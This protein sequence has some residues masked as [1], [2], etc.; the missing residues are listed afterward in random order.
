M[1]MDDEVKLLYI[2]TGAD[3]MCFFSLFGGI[4]SNR[5]KLIS[6]TLI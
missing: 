4:K 3:S 5:P 2:A 1:A 6:I